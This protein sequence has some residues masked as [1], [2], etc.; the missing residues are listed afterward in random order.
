MSSLLTPLLAEARSDDLARAARRAGGRA[1]AAADAD[2]GAAGVDGPGR[3]DREPTRRGPAR[4]RRGLARYWGHVHTRDQRAVR[5]THGR[6][7]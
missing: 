3:D 6:A 7:G 4:L 5:R 1:S 2:H